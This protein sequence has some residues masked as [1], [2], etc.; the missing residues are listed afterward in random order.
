[1]SI[2]ESIREMT[3]KGSKSRSLTYYDYSKIGDKLYSL[4]LIDN[5]KQTFLRSCANGN[6]QIFEKLSKNFDESVLL[7]GFQVACMHRQFEIVDKLLSI[8]PIDKNN[9]TLLEKE[10]YYGDIKIIDR[11]LTFYDT[12]TV[13]IREPRININRCK[14]LFLKGIN[15]IINLDLEDFHLRFYLYKKGLYKKS[16]EIV[17]IQDFKNFTNKKYKYLL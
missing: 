10:I 17:R 8:A 1:M 7:E 9:I 11:L 14:F 3:I 5:S 12:K 4:G 16:S 15:M 13:V 2:I 6:L